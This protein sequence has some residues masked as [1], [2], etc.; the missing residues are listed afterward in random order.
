MAKFGPLVSRDS[1]TEVWGMLERLMAHFHLVLSVVVIHVWLDLVHVK[2][3]A[4][5]GAVGVVTVGA[6]AVGAEVVGVLPLV[7]DKVI[8]QVAQR[9]CEC[10]L[11]DETWPMLSKLAEPLVKL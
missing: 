3:D 1:C 6:E 8:E 5:E 10:P 11:K 9:L 4:T 7:L 2:L